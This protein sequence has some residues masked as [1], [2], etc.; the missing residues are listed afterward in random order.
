MLDAAFDFVDPYIAEAIWTALLTYFGW[1][2]RWIAKTK[3]SRAALHSALHTGVDKV[4]DLLAV[5]ILKHPLAFTVDQYA[6]TVADHVFA[7]VPDALKFLMGQPWFMRLI[8][9]KAMT[10]AEQR[11]WIEGMAVAKLKAWAAEFMAKL[12]G[13]VLTG[14]L[15]RAD[16]PAVEPPYGMMSG[17]VMPAGQRP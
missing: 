17:G 3:E 16:A 1:V 11:A 15:Q 10:E 2:F 13:D 4:T 8:G 7:S 5:A 12:P 6:G 14:A 9:K